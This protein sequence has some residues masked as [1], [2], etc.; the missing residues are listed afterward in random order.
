MASFFRL[1]ERSAQRKETLKCFILGQTHPCRTLHVTRDCARG[2]AEGAT[3]EPRYINAAPLTS[4]FVKRTG[5]TAAMETGESSR[6]A[7]N[8]APD[9]SRWPLTLRLPAKAWPLFALHRSQAQ[10][11]GRAQRQRGF[12]DLPRLRRSSS[13]ARRRRPSRA[14]LP[15]RVQRRRGFRGG[16]GLLYHSALPSSACVRVGLP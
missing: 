2:P 10:R 4:R 7:A 3:S 12:G 13:Y 15:G 16:S 9:S 11:S 5:E 8:D 6:P 14:Q 1:Q